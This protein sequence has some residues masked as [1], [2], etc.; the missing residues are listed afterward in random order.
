MKFKY[1]LFAFLIAGFAGLL[2]DIFLIVFDISW[3]AS[4]SGI[5]AG[6]IFL[7]LIWYKEKKGEISQ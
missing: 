4:V 6:V 2:Y 7:A 3:R 1:Y 5:F